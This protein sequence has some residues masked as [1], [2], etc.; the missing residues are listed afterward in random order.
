MVAVL[1]LTV[2]VGGCLSLG[3]DGSGDCGEWDW[4]VSWEYAKC[5]TCLP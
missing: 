5:F 1:T 3:V 4:V 2:V